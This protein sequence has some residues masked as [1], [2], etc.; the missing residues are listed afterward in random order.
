MTR[1]LELSFTTCMFLST[2]TLLNVHVGS[3]INDKKMSIYVRTV[4][5]HGEKCKYM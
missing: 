2:K 5:Q 1:E 4:K 3:K